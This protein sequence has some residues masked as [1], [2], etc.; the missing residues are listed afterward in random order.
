VKTS[1]HPKRFPSLL[2][3]ALAK[4]GLVCLALGLACA[5]QQDPPFLQI[6][7]PTTGTIFN[8]GQT[9]SVSISSPA[10]A[11]FSAVGVIPEG[12]ITSGNIESSVPATFTVSIP[13]DI[14]CGPRLLTAMGT[15]T[16]GQTAQSAPV[17][18]DV[19]RPDMP[20]AL[21]AQTPASQVTLEALG[22]QFHV[23][24]AIF[25]EPS[26]AIVGQTSQLDGLSPGAGI[27]F[28]E[29]NGNAPTGGL[30][31]SSGVGFLGF[32][33]PSVLDSSSTGNP[34][35]GAVVNLLNTMVSN[36]SSFQS[37]NP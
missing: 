26:D 21:S 29:A 27:V 34:V 7:S 15:T 32:S 9:V 33:G 20:T 37:V 30:L 2:L 36:S 4:V 10:N 17:Q 19:E 14:D 35:P 11:S 1:D 13:T 22:Q 8:P 28:S 12:P 6:T 5:A 16:S 18:I 31:H 23:W 25:G 3:K 24:P